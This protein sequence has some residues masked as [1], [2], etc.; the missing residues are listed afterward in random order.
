MML[1]QLSSATASSSGFWLLTKPLQQVLDLATRRRHLHCSGT[2]CA[3]NDGDAGRSDDN[4]N[5][6]FSFVHSL[7]LLP[8]RMLW[9][10]R[11]E[12]L[13]GCVRCHS[14]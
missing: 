2:A 11:M 8:L 7:P 6:R 12:L 4:G 14:S 10:L 3:S 1:R 9:V 13:N 5:L